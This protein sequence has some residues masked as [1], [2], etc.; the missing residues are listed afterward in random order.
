MD[1][2]LMAGSGR[3][4]A[5]LVE[6]MGLQRLG[7]SCIGSCRT[8]KTSLVCMPKWQ[9]YLRLWKMLRCGSV[10]DASQ[11]AVSAK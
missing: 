4:I 9:D 1:C 11:I 3:K 6:H 2:G 7:R 5:V 8:G 10:E